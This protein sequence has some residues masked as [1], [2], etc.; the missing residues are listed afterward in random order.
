MRLRLADISLFGI[1]PVCLFFVTASLPAQNSAAGS[2]REPVK[3]IIDTDIGEDIDDILVT[4][5]ALNSPEFEVLAVTTVDGN[6]AARS[7]VARKLALLYGKPELPVAEGYVRGIPQEDTTYSGFSGGVRYGE[8][9]PDEQGL[10]PGSLLR[11]DELIARLALRYPGQV[12]LVTIGSMSNAGQLL[13]RYPEAA[14][15]LKQIV[16]NGGNFSSPE[17][18]IG[19]NLRY[20]PLAA[21]IVSR[22]T[23]PWVLLSESTTRYCGLREEDVARLKN[24]GRPTTELLLQAIHWWHTNKTDATALPHVS[25]LNTFAY[26]LGGWVET[27]PGKVFIEIG[28]EG[29]L[30]GF[31]AEDDPRGRVLLGREIP[32]EKAANLREVLME[33]LLAPPRAR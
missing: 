15:K 9:A 1:V 28:P 25:D 32:R 19:W 20:D 33:R 18:S 7:R 5:F 13:V 30:P 26:L 27:T 4:A 17:Q 22:S 29:T 6:V 31:R 16:T 11:A 23:V 14:A 10:P 3:V 21:A 8:I 12:S 24:A 2:P